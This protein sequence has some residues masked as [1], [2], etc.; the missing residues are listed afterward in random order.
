MK[1]IIV[2][3]LGKLDYV[4]TLKLQESLWAQ[5]DTGTFKDT[6][7]LVEHSPQVYSYGRRDTPTDLLMD[8][9]ELQKHGIDVVHVGRGGNITW[10]GPGQLVGYPI[11]Y[12]GNYQK[13]V[14]WY[15]TN[16]QK[17]VQDTLSHFGIP[18]GIHCEPTLAGVWVGPEQNRKIAAMGVQLSR[19]YTMHG[20]ALNV[21]SDLTAYSKI[22]PC[23][24]SDPKFSVTSMEKELQRNITIEEVTPLLI[25]NF[26]KAFNAKMEFE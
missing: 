9:K 12:L 24:I 16:V 2:R 11:L 15:F 23:G 19:W 17:A 26:G 4:K 22:I 14:R 3:N 21:N 18:S 10:H 20:F 6:L 7:L 1:R 5:R 8:E 25:E 13:S